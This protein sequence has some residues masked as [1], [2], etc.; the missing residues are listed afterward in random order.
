MLLTVLALTP[1]TIEVGRTSEP[2]KEH[3]L[4][5]V[6]EAH[7]EAQVKAFQIYK[8]TDKEI[9][10]IILDSFGASGDD[11][12]SV[13]RCESGLRSGVISRTSDV[14]IAQIN[15]KAHWSN[16]PGKT[17]A[18]KIAWLQVPQNNVNFAYV[19]YESNGWRDWSASRPCHG[20][21]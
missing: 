4:V 12:I 21:Y 13:F 20:Y 5:N 19:L 14:G 17:R 8:E 16:I 2:K 10:E 7:E 18:E 6:A 11:A 3:H 9:I 15:L 1:R